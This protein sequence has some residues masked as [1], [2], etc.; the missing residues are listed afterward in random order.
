SLARLTAVFT[1]DF[2]ACKEVAEAALSAAH[3]AGAREQEANARIML[4]VALCYLGEHEAGIASLQT[5]RELAESIGAE[6][7]AVR[8]HLNL[9]DSLEVLGSHGQAA[10]V[11]ERGLRLAA[12]VGLARHIYGMLLIINRSEALIH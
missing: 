2:V 5:G 4:G 6:A 3:A 9:S 12:R 7:T 8:A 1:S 11:A 10:D